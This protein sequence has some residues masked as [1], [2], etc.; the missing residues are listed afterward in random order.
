MSSRSDNCCVLVD[1]Y[2][3]L[4]QWDRVI[5]TA[6]QMAKVFAEDD[7]YAP[8]AIRD[9]AAAYIK[10]GL[11][12]EAQADIRTLAASDPGWAKWTR[13]LRKALAQGQ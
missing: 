4:Q 1:T 2:E 10:K 8:R 7:Y 12:V 13:H 6:T 5:E 3:S 11:R 9:R